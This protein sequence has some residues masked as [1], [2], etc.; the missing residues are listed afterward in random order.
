MY[1]PVYKSS[2]SLSRHLLFRLLVAVGL[3]AEALSIIT[4]KLHDAVQIYFI[5]NTLNNKTHMKHEYVK[6]YNF[7]TEVFGHHTTVHKFF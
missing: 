3:Y 1:T 6:S 5:S 7:H 2:L 4:L